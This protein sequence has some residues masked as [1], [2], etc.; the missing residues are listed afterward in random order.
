MEIRE[1]TRLGN[2]RLYVGQISNGKIGFLWLPLNMFRNRVAGIAELALDADYAFS[3]S[4][5]WTFLIDLL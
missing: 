3:F 4:T 5:M 2:N 1:R